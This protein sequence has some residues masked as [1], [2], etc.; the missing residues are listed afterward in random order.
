MKYAGIWW[1][2]HI[3]KETWHMGP[4]HGATTEN[5]IRHIDF[6]HQ[7]GIPGLLIEGWNKGWENW[8]GTDAFNFLEPYEDFDIN[9]VREDISKLNSTVPLI[10]FSSLNGQGMDRWLQWLKEK[11]IKSIGSQAKFVTE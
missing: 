6:C 1:G 3:G 4:N 5:A 7:N 8:F 11:R 10:E 9:R 2:M